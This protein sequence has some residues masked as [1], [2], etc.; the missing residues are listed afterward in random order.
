[1]NRA[2]WF[3]LGILSGAI[4]GLLY[5]P[6]KG[7]HMRSMLASKSKQGRRFI[8]EQTSDWKDNVSETFGRGRLAM[9]KSIRGFMG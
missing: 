3:L 6:Q 1:M 2:N 5:A 7:K 9:S 8:R 4:A